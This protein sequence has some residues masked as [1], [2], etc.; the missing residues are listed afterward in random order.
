[1]KAFAVVI[2]TL[3][4]IAGYSQNSINSYKYILVPERYNFAKEDNQ[5]GLNTTTKQLLT[6]KGFTALLNN[7][8]LP[9]E[10][11][12]NKCN[13]LRAEVVEKKSMFVTKL[14]LLLKD[15]QGNILFQTKEGRSRE[16]EFPVAYDL[17]LRD[18]LTSLNDLPYKYDSTALAQTQ[19][20]TTA[21]P[22]TT[23]TAALPTPAATPSS[24]AQTQPQTQTPA[25]STAADITGT[26]YAQIIP[27]GYQ[28]IDTTPK[29]VLTL[30]KTSAE[31]SFIAEGGP[32]NGIAFKK[33]G[34]WFFEYYKD[35][36]L[37]SQKLSIKF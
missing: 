35:G 29:K 15:C 1:M 17:A 10:L 8:Q 23:S 16:K 19:Q 26:L 37:V 18:A 4:T 3:F 28:L 9:L 21:T 2:F 31:D 22:G 7:E 5:Y 30:L 14:T 32:S 20:A 13:A 33:N 6:A 25:Q 12:S 27:N 36:K 24:P 34:D 11:A